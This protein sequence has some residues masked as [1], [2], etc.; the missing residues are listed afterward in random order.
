M[1]RW[2]TPFNYS[3]IIP[4]MQILYGKIEIIYVI[5]K[6]KR[7]TEIIYITFWHEKVR[8]KYIHGNVYVL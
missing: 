2:T 5:K 4:N 7:T 6:F 3:A 1:S 8:S